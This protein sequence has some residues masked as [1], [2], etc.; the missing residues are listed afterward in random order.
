MVDNGN[1]R[2][3]TNNNCGPE[4]GIVR[5]LIGQIYRP[6]PWCYH[7]YQLMCVCLLYSWWWQTRSLWWVNHF[8]LQHF[9]CGAADNATYCKL[10]EMHWKQRDKHKDKY[11]GAG[12]TADRDCHLAWAY[13]GGLHCSHQNQSGHTQ[14]GGSLFSSQCAYTSV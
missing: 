10:N 8:I 6:H 5:P 13:K 12:I 14:L 4:H 1:T 3:A 9:V 2:F 11:H 7:H